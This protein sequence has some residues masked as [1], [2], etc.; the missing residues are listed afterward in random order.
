MARTTILALLAVA[1]TVPMT[2]FSVAPAAGQGHG[3]HGAADHGAMATAEGLPDGWLMRLDR[4]AATPDMA[5]FAV[6]APGWHVKTGRAGAGIFWMPG[7]TATGEYTLRSTFHLFSPASHAEAF[8]LFLGG[9]KLDIAGQEYLYFL[10]R[11]T[12]EYLIKRRIGDKTEN[13][14]G[15]TRHEAIP[16]APAGEQGPTRYEV[17]VSAGADQVRLLVNGTAVHTLERSRVDVDGLM[18]L[19]INHM[20]DLHV[21]GLEVD[22]GK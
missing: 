22:P 10:V 9:E 20:L 6:M 13:V 21:E 19:R 11:Q 14:V 18:G 2:L 5:D 16:V 15:W 1:L 3:H 12:G 17:A 7:M 4:S 8:G